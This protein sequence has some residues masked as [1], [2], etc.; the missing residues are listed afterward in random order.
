M[1]IKTRPGFRCECW[2]ED[3]TEQRQP[4]LRALFDAY[5]E[6]QA[7]HWLS[8][9]LREISPGFDVD[10]SDDAWE[11]LRD[12]RI[13]TRRALLRR[14]PCTVSA[15]HKDIRVTWAIRPV[16]YLPLVQRELAAL[17]APT[18][19]IKPQPAD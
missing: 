4:A 14:E 19:G 5:T 15:S 13:E 6:V 16:L 18:D 11:R 7:D 2:T 17:P 10:R 9:T 3:L 1:L 12:D 8:V